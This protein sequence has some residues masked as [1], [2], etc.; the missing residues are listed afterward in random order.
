MRSL[1]LF[2]IIAN[3]ICNNSLVC[4]HKGQEYSAVNYSIKNEFAVGQEI[5]KPIRYEISRCSKSQPALLKPGQSTSNRISTVMNISR[6]F[7]L[8]MLI[9]RCGDIALN[10]GPA[11]KCLI[12]KGTVRRNQISVNCNLCN[13]LLHVKCCDLTD[14]AGPICHICFPNNSIL[15]N[16]T[17]GYSNSNHIVN[18]LQNLISKHGLTICHQISVDC[19]EKLTPCMFSLIHIKEFI[20]LALAK[21]ISMTMCMIIKLR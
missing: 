1:F 16:D 11:G 17:T 9:E 19:L 14:K 2:F 12:C 6:H 3:F 8:A 10:P 20:S 5:T 7:M 13:G 18:D 15:N 4:Y 21:H